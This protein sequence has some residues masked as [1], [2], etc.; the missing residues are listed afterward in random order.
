MKKLAA[1]FFATLYFLATAGTVIA[2]HYCMGNELGVTLG[3][4][5]SEICDNCHMDKNVGTQSGCCSDENHFVKLTVD[6]QVPDYVSTPQMPV[7]FIST[8]VVLGISDATL[9]KPVRI[10]DKVDPPDI[11]IYT[12][13]CNYRI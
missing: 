12:R 8:E 13:N 4:A 7:V 3:Y 5:E 2:M 9:N 11:P 10:T 6:H 1:I